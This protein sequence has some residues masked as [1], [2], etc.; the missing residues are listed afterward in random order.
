MRTSSLSL[1]LPTLDWL[2]FSNSCV[3]GAAAAPLLP[4]AQ[5]L[6]LIEY[7][8]PLLVQCTTVAP[9]GLNAGQTVLFGTQDD[10]AFAGTFAINVVFGQPNFF[11][12][13][14]P[15]SNGIPNPAIFNL[16]NPADPK[17]LVPQTTWQIVAYAQRALITSL[18]TN[19]AAVNIG[20]GFVADHYAMAPGEEYLI[21]MPQT[22]YG[23]RCDLSKWCFASSANA[24]ISVIYV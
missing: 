15:R 14:I 9:H 24:T 20:P 23:A 10:P 13:S 5:A 4:A 12:Y 8:T 21:E 1:A 6:S 7:P 2:R 16:S 3:G 11:S 19:T 22:Q 17:I 18:S